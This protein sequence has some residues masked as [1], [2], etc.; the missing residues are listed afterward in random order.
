M[1][2]CN[3][4]S[5]YRFALA[6][7]LAMMLFLIIMP[8]HAQL[9]TAEERG[10]S[11]VVITEK[12]EAVAEATVVASYAS[13]KKEIKTNASGHFR[14]EVPSGTVTLSVNGKYLSSPEKNGR[15]LRV[16]G[17]RAIER[18]AISSGCCTKAW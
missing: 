7:A 3:S 12:N 11:G 16:V 4:S 14:L 8:L 17:R 9:S 15:C 18:S 10:L 13:G 2:V 5:E 1:P 6:L